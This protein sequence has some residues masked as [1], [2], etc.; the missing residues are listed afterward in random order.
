M[1]S[2]ISSCFTETDFMNAVTMPP[3]GTELD[4]KNF[5]LKVTKEGQNP[6]L[7]P[8]T[9]IVCSSDGMSS[10]LIS[11]FIIYGHFILFIK[12]RRI[13]LA[14]AKECRKTWFTIYQTIS[15]QCRQFQAE[16]STQMSSC[17]IQLNM[18]VSS[19]MSIKEDLPAGTIAASRDETNP[20]CFILSQHS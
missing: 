14:D 12:D 10:L 4:Y 11:M 16:F 15:S 6:W 7:E 13:V 9:V 17:F 3:L 18:S 20:T 1:I 5:D 2:F 19:E 8:F